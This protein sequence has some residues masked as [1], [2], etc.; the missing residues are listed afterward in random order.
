MI[1]NHPALL[2]LAAVSQSYIWNVA[3]MVLLQGAFRTRMFEFSQKVLAVFGRKS[4]IPV[5]IVESTRHR[6]LEEFPTVEKHNISKSI[7]PVT[8]WLLP[9]PNKRFT[10]TRNHFTKTASA[11]PDSSIRGSGMIIW[12]RVLKCSVLC[13]HAHPGAGANTSAPLSTQTVSVLACHFLPWSKWNARM[14]SISPLN[15]LNR[16]FPKQC[17]HCQP[18]LDTQEHPL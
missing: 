6:F 10:A 3:H 9:L 16:R 1:V 8:V 13:A 4:A 5:L 15:L 12:V 7:Y 11:V 14:G 18:C 17:Q 2:T